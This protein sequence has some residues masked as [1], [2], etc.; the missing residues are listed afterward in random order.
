MVEIT[1]ALSAQII[2][3]ASAFGAVVIFLY[4]SNKSR[5]SVGKCREF[6]ADYCRI[7]RK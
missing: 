3:I 4:T 7:A 1:N 5:I 2:G 6:V